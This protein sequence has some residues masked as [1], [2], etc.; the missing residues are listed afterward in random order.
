MKKLILF[1]VCFVFAT[2]AAQ[3][4]VTAKKESKPVETAKVV[5]VAETTKVVTCDTTLIIKI[6]TTTT[7]TATKVDTLK[8]TK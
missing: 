5:A 3:Q 8:K 1:T 4:A 6:L 7:T 2:V